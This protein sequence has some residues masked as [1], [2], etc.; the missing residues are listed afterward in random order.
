MAQLQRVRQRTLRLQQLQTEAAAQAAA[1]SGSRSPSAGAAPAL[2][3]PELVRSL[4]SPDVP[5][6]GNFQKIVKPVESGDDES[7]DSAGGREQ[8]DE[9]ELPPATDDRQVS[10]GSFLR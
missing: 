6:I 7:V 5:L 3:Q 10:L 4:F 9:G 1:I 8:V 2:A